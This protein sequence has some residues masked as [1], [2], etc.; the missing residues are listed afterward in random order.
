MG[1][2]P[3]LTGPTLKCIHTTQQEDKYHTS[4]TTKGE[5]QGN[6]LQAWDDHSFCYTKEM[7]KGIT[8]ALHP[9]S[10]AACHSAASQSFVFYPQQVNPHLTTEQGKPYG[11]L[12]FESGTWQHSTDSRGLLW[13]TLCASRQDLSLHGSPHWKKQARQ[14]LKQ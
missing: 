12:G 4:W 1:N 6:I 7:G 8:R 2:L 3:N 10:P 11:S 14:L 13:S 5:N 9:N